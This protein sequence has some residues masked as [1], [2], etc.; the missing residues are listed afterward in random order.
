MLI[1]AH[2]F[3][4]EDGMATN[5][6]GDPVV[7]NP[8]YMGNIR[9]FFTADDIDHMQQK[10]ID[11]GTYDG[12]KS[13]AVQ[14]YS[15][16]TPPAYLPPDPTQQWS[17]NRCQTFLNWISTNYP[18]GIPGPVPDDAAVVAAP[19]ARI[20]RD[21]ANLTA[22]ERATLTTAFQGLLNRTATDPNGYFMLAGIHGLPQL[23]CQHHNDPYNP[24]HRVYLKMFEDALR[25][26]DGC[27]DVTLPYW[28]ISQPIPPLLSAPPFDA[29][30]FPQPIGQYAAGDRTQRNNQA[31]IDQNLQQFDFFGDVAT[32]L[33]QVRWGK[34]SGFGGGSG[35][36]QFSIQAHDSGHLSTGPTMADQN[37]ASY[38]P[39]FWFYHC[40][41]DRFWLSWQKT[42]HA[43]DWAT[44]QSLLDSTAFWKPPLNVIN[45]F[46]TTTDQTI[47]F[48]VDYEDPAV[49]DRPL[50]N[51][52]RSL[53]VG[54]NFEIKRQSPIAVTVEDIE[55]LNVPGS[56]VVHL[57]AD[58]ETVASRAFFQPT[59]PRNCDTCATL[60]KVSL[61]FRVDRDKVLDKKLSVKIDVPGQ[62]AIGAAFPLSQVGQPTIKASLLLDEI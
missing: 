50:E 33:S 10:G 49:S 13:H 38:D 31:T 9:Y 35:Y 30:T 20:R 12:V 32:S 19:A 62:E 24:W 48:G 55:R 2:R 3:I 37:V 23:Y 25:S 46:T 4:R 54:R 8:T 39:I 21:V 14:I 41:L 45:P 51:Q 6:G 5:P 16:V 29:Y 58:G 36:Q 52:V 61:E 56:F 34:Y 43:T 47:A 44:F 26:V 57:L 42:L 60:P 40:N 1:S 59:N 7:D 27:E 53:A 28:D 17:A 15:A 22:A 18:M 11:L